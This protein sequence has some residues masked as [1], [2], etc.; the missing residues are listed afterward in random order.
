M[1][2]ATLPEPSGSKM[3]QL[4]AIVSL[5][6]SSQKPGLP[7]HQGPTGDPELDADDEVLLPVEASMAP[8]LLEEPLV[9]EPLDDA[10]PDEL[11]LEGVLP[12][13]L[14][15][16]ASAAPLEGVGFGSA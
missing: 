14:E 8:S 16:D 2:H 3:F 4:V 5:S 12:E 1:F 11:A 6:K 9:L 10:E 7:L 13:E 15:A